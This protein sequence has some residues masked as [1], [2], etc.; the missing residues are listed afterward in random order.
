MHTTKRYFTVFISMLLLVAPI[1]GQKKLWGKWY[2]MVNS[3]TFNKNEIQEK[4]KTG[5]NILP[6]PSLG[7][8]S[9]LG[10]QLGAMADFIDFGNGEYYPGYR[11]RFYAQFSYFTEGALLYRLFYD[12]QHLIRGVR[13]TVDFTMLPQP[14]F[15]FYGFN[16]YEA[17]LT[18]DQ[19]PDFHNI[20]RTLARLTLDFEGK[21]YRNIRWHAGLSAFSFKLGETTYNSPS[22][23]LSLYKLYVNKGLIREEE[24]SG[25]EHLYLKAG[26]VYDSRNSEA[27]PTRGIRSELFFSYTPDFIYNGGYSHLKLAFIHSTYKSLIPDKLTLA[28]R[29]GYYGTIGG[30]QVPFYLQ[31][32]INTLMMRRITSEGLG[33]LSSLRGIL[34]N[35]VVGDGIAWANIEMRYRIIGMSAFGQYMYLTANPFLDFGAVV[36]P[37][38][39]TEVRNAAEADPNYSRYLYSGERERLHFSTGLGLKLIINR[40]IVFS[41]EMGKAFNSQDG[42][43][44]QFSFGSNY[45]F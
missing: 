27:D 16:G 21:I 19:G 38:R 7:Y 28:T 23:R 6:V 22:D 5:W 41:G 29:V 12:T 26:L 9:D 8:S 25:G 18:I 39:Q 44:W 42:R 1:H 20:E 11:H 31:S 33:G 3:I 36:Q 37:F 24:K 34:T 17:P 2:E 43:N 30:G 14:K 45:I 15:E 10:F 32:N 35:R 13:T 4:P 40:N